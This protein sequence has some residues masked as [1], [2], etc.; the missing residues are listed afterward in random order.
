[1]TEL[2]KI[3]CNTL[4][5][6]PNVQ[7]IKT[8]LI[9]HDRIRIDYNVNAKFKSSNK[10]AEYIQRI[11]QEFNVEIHKGEF[12]ELEFYNIYNLFSDSELLRIS[13]QLELAVKDYRL[14]S[15]KLI[16]EFENKYNH[17]FTDPE[18]SIYSIREKLDSDKNR[19]TKQ[20]M[21]NFHGGDVCFSN[22]KTGQVVD[23]NLKFDGYYG[24]LD[25]WF[26]QYFMETTNQFTE[27]SNNFR[28]NTPKLVQA[29]NSLQ[30][31]NIVSL[32]RSKIFNTE[33]LIWNKEKVHNKS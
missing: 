30:E 27:L 22:S 12:K 9:K 16:K 17:S 19:L 29:L 1:M 15:E 6:L 31:K 3:Y 28:E 23:I 21:Y 2:R 14:T 4:E 33:K 7:I 20:W 32:I 8:E 18:K 24:V 13:N 26:F 25:L 11:Q 10:L 5:E